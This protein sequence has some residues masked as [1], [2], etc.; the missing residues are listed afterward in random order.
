V[1]EKELE[2]QDWYQCQ[3]R[4]GKEESRG[5]FQTNITSSKS[6]L[7]AKQMQFHDKFLGYLLTPPG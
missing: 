7:L 5:T 1:L 4:L 2:I 3:M 6:N